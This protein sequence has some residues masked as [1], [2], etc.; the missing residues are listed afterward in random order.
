MYMI[1]SR[2]LTFGS[3]ECNNYTKMV[4]KGQDWCVCFEKRSDL[5]VKYTRLKGKKHNSSQRRNNTF[6]NVD[7]MIAEGQHNFLS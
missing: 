2:P 7:I 1:A 6:I 3:F 5:A 4:L